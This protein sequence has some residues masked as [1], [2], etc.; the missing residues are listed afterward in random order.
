MH[1]HWPPE[2]LRAIEKERFHFE[3]HLSGQMLLSN[4]TKEKLRSCIIRYHH[5][6]GLDLCAVQQFDPLGLFVFNE[7]FVH[8][9]IDE[10]LNPQLF[11]R[12]DE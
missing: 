2:K 11:A 10:I 8:F 4:H 7:D 9:R 6:F 5:F 1:R 3:L 12:R